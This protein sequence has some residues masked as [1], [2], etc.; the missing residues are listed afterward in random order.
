MYEHERWPDRLHGFF[1]DFYAPKSDI[2][3]INGAS[4]ATGSDYFSFCFALHIPTDVD[5]VIV[6]LGVNDVGEP[7]DLKTMEDLLRGLLD[8]ESQPA[9]MLLEV[10]GFSGAG[11]GGGGGRYHLPI[12]Q[13]YDVPVINQRH[14][15]AS[16]FGRFPDLM[17]HYF[18]TNGWGDPDM[19]HLN[20]RGHHDA[21]N[22]IASLLRDTTCAL[23]AN[24]A[25]R[26]PAAEPPIKAV[27]E[28]TAHATYDDQVDTL[29]EDVPSTLEALESGWAEEEKTWFEPYKRPKDVKEGEEGEHKAEFR[30]P[31]MWQR[32]VEHGL[33]PRMEFLAGWNPDPNYR[34]PTS[35][36]TC[37]S[38]K[39][40]DAKFN[41]TPTFADGFEWWRHPDHNDKPYIIAR[42][43]GARVEFEIPVHA[44]TIK[45]YYLKSER[46]SLG[47]IRCWV[48]DGEKEGK[49]GVLLNGWWK[50][51]WL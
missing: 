2:P 49:E 44:G 46:M 23:V 26:L 37:F 10:L 43:P 16:H 9:V 38:T 18:D 41:L 40:T 12:A 36:P 48:D 24:P 50:R 35:R 32:R 22:I 7:E 19:R 27:L 45:M 4:P 34:R 11:M 15:T 6:E 28:K 25:F 5:L 20:A 8:L 13:Y 14:P 42:K 51:D 17:P 47:K 29:Y 39:A 33:V 21:S 1:K 31:G 30:R 3:V